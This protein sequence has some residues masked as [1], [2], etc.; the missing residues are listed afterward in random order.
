M[1]TGEWYV[2]GFVLGLSFVGFLL[3]VLLGYANNQE[4]DKGEMRRAI[5]AF[6]II[7][8]GLLV[9]SSFFLKG[10][11]VPDE[12]RGLFIGTIATIIGFYF[13]SRSAQP[14]PPG[15]AQPQPPGG[16]QPQRP[17]GAQPQPPGGARP[18][19]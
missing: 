13:G 17:G 5:T 16:A 14:Q 4:L 19:P 18:P 11:N 8:F 10:V 1:S 3:M 12:I 9:T 15:G 6:F 7:L 2:L